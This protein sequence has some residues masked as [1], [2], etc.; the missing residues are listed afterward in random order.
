M[1]L[2]LGGP[3]DFREL[4]ARPST[5]STQ[6]L[7]SGNP[8]QLLTSILVRLPTLT[9]IV[10]ELSR[11]SRC[12]FMYIRCLCSPFASRKVLVGGKRKEKKLRW[13]V[14]HS[15]CCHRCCCCLK[16]NLLPHNRPWLSISIWAK[17]QQ[18]QRNQSSFHLFSTKAFAMQVII[19]PSEELEKLESKGN[20]MLERR[21]S[22]R[23]EAEEE[24]ALKGYRWKW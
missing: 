13:I 2:Q 12:L 8:N 22:E 21:E 14:V 19:V 15:Q 10:H 7:H 4:I 5:R 17:Q 23:R 20:E 18:Q 16:F 6:S 1:E 11:T 9:H 3:S 24:V